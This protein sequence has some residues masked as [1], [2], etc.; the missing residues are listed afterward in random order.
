MAVS[1]DGG[2]GDRKKRLDADLNLVPYID[3]LDRYRQVQDTR[4]LWASPLDQHPNALAN[5]IAA[6]EILAALAPT[7]GFDGAAK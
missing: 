5:R 4:T 7:W 2:G 1:I 6:D 3:L